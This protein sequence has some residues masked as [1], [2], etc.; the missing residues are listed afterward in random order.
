MNISHSLGSLE[1]QSASLPGRLETSSAVFL[2]VIA[3]ARFAA[4]LALEANVTLSMIIFAVSGFSNKN[5][6]NAFARIVDTIFLTSALP[7]LV[8]VCPSY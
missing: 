8:F 3:L 2:L 5:L 6:S 4:I 1:E 7:N